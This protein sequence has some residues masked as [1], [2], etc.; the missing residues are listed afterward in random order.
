MA[1]KLL[2][3]LG[4]GLG[5]GSIIFISTCF[6]SRENSFIVINSANLS[7][8]AVGVLKFVFAEGRPFFIDPR[9]HP[10]SCKTLEYGYPSGHSVGSTGAYVTIVC[11][12]L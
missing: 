4:D 2:S 7:I 6:L 8:T 11:L 1:A 3:Y 10:A 12:L 9:I 5:L